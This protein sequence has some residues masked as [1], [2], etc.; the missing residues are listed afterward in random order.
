[1]LPITITENLWQPKIHK[2]F[3]LKYKSVY[4]QFMGTDYMLLCGGE[5]ILDGG[6]RKGWVKEA[7]WNKQKNLLP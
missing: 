3:K 5:E 6:E 7:S 4:W 2:W 1:M